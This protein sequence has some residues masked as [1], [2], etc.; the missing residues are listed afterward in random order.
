MP[1]IKPE[2]RERLDP[3]IE[4]L[5]GELLAE[6]IYDGDSDGQHTTRPTPGDLNYIITRICGEY[7]SHQG[8]SY[9]SINDLIGVLEC[10]KQ[11]LYRRVASKYEDEKIG[12][13]GDAYPEEIR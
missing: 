7:I 1:Y 2:R 6:D 13:N 11:E 12:Q 5:L 4:D 8:L 10:A 9:S 3:W